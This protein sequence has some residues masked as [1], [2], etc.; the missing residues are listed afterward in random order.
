MAGGIVIAQF[1]GLLEFCIPS[2]SSGHTGSPMKSH[3]RSMRATVSA[4]LL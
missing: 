3:W 4:G 2:L 1:P